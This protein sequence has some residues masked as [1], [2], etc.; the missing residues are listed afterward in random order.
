[1]HKHVIVKCSS[2]YPS[3][4]TGLLPR[5]STKKTLKNSQYS[6][7]VMVNNIYIYI[8]IFIYIYTIVAVSVVTLS[9][10]A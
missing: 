1:M 3:T 4:H 2:D 6:N 5:E 10:L 8:Y 9:N 7:L